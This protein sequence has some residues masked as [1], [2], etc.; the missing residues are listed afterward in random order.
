MLK[1]KIFFHKTIFKKEYFIDLKYKYCYNT[2]VEKSQDR[3][4]EK[5]MKSV[6]FERKLKEIFLIAR[7]AS[8]ISLL[9]ILSLTSIFIN[10]SAENAI[11]VENCNLCESYSQKLGEEINEFILLDTEKN[12]TVSTQV[13]VAIN[14]YR[15][16]IIDLQSHPEVEKRSLENDILLAYSKGNAAGKTAW[17]YYYNIY[18]FENDLSIERINAKYSAVKS[19]IASASQSSV[20]DAECEVMLDELNRLIYT[21]RAKNLATLGD[22]LTSSALISGTVEGFKSIS[23]PDIFGVE[24]QKSYDSLVSELGLQRVR[25]ALLSEGR[26]IFAQIT[27]QGDFDVSPSAA[28]LAYNLKNSDSVK[29]MNSAALD[30]CTELLAIDEKK[31]YGKSLKKELAALAEEACAR[32]TENQRAA[33]FGDIFSNY[34]AKLKKAEAKDSIYLLLLGDKGEG[35]EELIALEQ[36]YNAQNKIIDLCESDAE[37]EQALVGAKAELFLLEN[38]II[39]E[40]PFSSLSAEDEQMAILALTKYASLEDKVKERLLTEINIIAEKYNYILTEKMRSFL[41]DDALYLDFC[42]KISNELKNISRESIDGFYNQASRVPSKAL[43]LA[44]VI[45]EYRAILAE[46]NY[47]GYTEGERSSLIDI[48]NRFFDNLS[49]I[50]PA[51]V[52]IYADEISNAKSSAIR[53]LNVTDQ[54][55]RVRIATRSSSNPAI[56]EELKI[57]TERISACTEKSEM[58]LQASRAIYKIQ[59]LLTADAITNQCESI[60]LSIEKSEF[61]TDGEKNSFILS[62]LTL[63]EKSKNAKEAENLTALEQLWLDFEISLSKIRAESS[64]IELS[65]AISE[66]LDKATISY[67]SLVEKLDALEYIP[68][69]K[70]EE[71]YNSALTLKSTAIEQIPLLSTSEDI[72][73]YYSEF[74]KSLDNILKEAQNADLDG[75]K[76]FLLC[77]FDKYDHIKANYS[78]ENYNKILDIKASA[79]DKLS[80]ATSKGECDSIIKA[81]LNEVLLVNDILAD[82]KES[83]LAALL[84]KLESLK[85][86]SPLYSASSFAKI[87]GLYDGGKLEIGKISGIENLSLVKQ[88]LSKYLTL[89]SAVRRDRAYTSENAYDISAPSLRY[90]DGYDISSEI[91]GSVTLTDGIMSGANLSIRLADNSQKSNVEAL[92]RR[93]AKKNVIKAYTP[94]DKTTKKL[95]KSASVAMTLDITLSEIYSEASGYTLQMLLPNELE[96][97]NILGLAFINGESVEFYPVTRSDQLLT[98][99]LEHFSKYYIVVE[100][101]VNVKPLLMIL[102]GLLIVEFIVLIALLYIRHKR[103]NE[104]IANSEQSNLPDLPLS[105]LV[106][107]SP[108]L[109]KIYPENGIP[110]AILLV[111]AVVALA[112][113]IALLIKNEATR[114]KEKSQSLIEGKPEPLLLK[115]GKPALLQDGKAD[116]IKE[117]QFFDVELEEACHI[118]ARSKS[119]TARAEIDLDLIAESFDTG[120]SVSLQSLKAKGLID[121]NAE[122]IRIFSKGNLIKPLKIEADEFSNAAKEVIKLSGGEIV[123]RK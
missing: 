72:V 21:E 41:P 112:A 115:D 68:S 30:F 53:A 93:A 1:S 99:E 64:A 123:E 38:K 90:P 27:P 59:R 108:I 92:I 44:S 100:S 37:L 61:L 113:T 31:P 73:N 8:L 5:T 63:A 120:E 16:E 98:V 103:N 12:K 66:Y 54:T 104:E 107:I 91:L 71:I 48:L 49:V 67:N 7:R 32:G 85:K 121:D 102:V 122:H 13:T 19:S 26:R 45:S 10:V 84:L 47:E 51:D 69:A 109:T 57:A 2:F 20:L 50:D 87:E 18:T 46:P 3:K 29:K 119:Q 15:K 14:E 28:L 106:P 60:K 116:S 62:I 65:R 55:A 17:V 96:N 33:D 76:S 39:V 80:S 34:Q 118:G 42:E 95:L 75:Y 89:I 70:S 56:I 58:I 114:G 6:V 22:S 40:N 78:A 101:T 35:N 97:E 83:A 43:A 110:L 11:R 52:A 9:A 86:L 88:T 25:D 24:Y 111:V 79:E 23:S 94:I 117:E 81:A 77:E 74:L 4:E 36:K 105:A 82:D